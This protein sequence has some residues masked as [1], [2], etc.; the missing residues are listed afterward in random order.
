MKTFTHS[1]VGAIYALLFIANPAKSQNL[2]RPS[3]FV[4]RFYQ[5]GFADTGSGS[6]FEIFNSPT[7]L[8][9]DLADPG[10][11]VLTANVRPLSPGSYN[12]VY[13]VISNR[14]RLAGSDGTGCYISSGN[15]TISNIGGVAGYSSFTNNLANAATVSNPA[16]LWENTFGAV[17]DPGFFGPVTP[18]VTGSV[19]NN[20]VNL[21]SFLATAADPLNPNAPG[22]RST[23]ERNTFFGTLSQPINILQQSN[24][25]IQ[26]TVNTSRAA[27]LSP[28]CDRFNTGP[29]IQFGFLVSEN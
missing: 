18:A 24:G 26:F 11:T 29:D 16:V 6:R 28:A 1:L 19:N 14:Y 2:F 23:R 22:D 9:I 25:S 20:V 12:S 10:S 8:D 5:I 7:G 17:T 21:I 13:V 27:N 4:V 3:S 15:Y